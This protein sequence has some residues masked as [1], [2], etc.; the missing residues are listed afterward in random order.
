MGMDK[1]AKCLINFGLEP[2]SIARLKG[3]DSRLRILKRKHQERKLLSQKMHP[4][5]GWQL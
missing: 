2:L 3:K 4:N 1:V 5:V